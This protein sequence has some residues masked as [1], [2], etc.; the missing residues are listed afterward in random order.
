MSDTFPSQLD[1]LKAKYGDNSGFEAAYA[2]LDLHLKWAAAV[3]ASDPQEAI[4]QCLLA[5]DCQATI[6]TFATG[7]GEGLASMAALYE[8]MGK[9]A[10]L[11]ETLANSEANSAE[12]TGRLK[13]ALAIWQK[14]SADPNGIGNRTPAK[15][16]IQRLKSRIAV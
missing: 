2:F 1:A 16:R 4:E 5:E 14:I 7:S 9:R 15:S 3:E 11:E 10:D 13:R 6:G 8:I 12:S